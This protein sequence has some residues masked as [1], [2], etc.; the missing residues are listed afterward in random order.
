M[1]A[2]IADDGTEETASQARIKTMRF[3]ATT[4][5]RLDAAVIK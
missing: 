1:Y 4:T 5:D 2:H 3:I